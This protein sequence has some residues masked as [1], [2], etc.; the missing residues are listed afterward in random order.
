MTD[1][2]NPWGRS[3]RKK[4]DTHFPEKREAV[5]KA[6]AALFR[7]QGYERAS[8]NDLADILQITKPTIYYY[9]HSKEQL[10]LDILRAAQSEILASFAKAAASRGSGYEKLRRIMVDYA[11]VMISDH[12]ACMARIPSR[13]FE[14]PAARAE[15]EQRIK[16][17]DGF[18]YAIIDEGISDGT[19]K[20]VDRAVALHT[21]FGSLNWT[22]YWAKSDGRLGPEALAEAQVELLLGGVRGAKAPAKRQKTEEAIAA[23]ARQARV[24][25]VA[26]PVAK[27]S[28]AP[29]LQEPGLAKAIRAKK[30][31]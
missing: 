28:D 29:K 8:L 26:A 5:V 3:P 27:I 21:L 11:L 14:E 7:N 24:R 15:V 12:G 22:A 23:P 16:E 2:S 10:L 20:I 1:A 18:I 4:R 19:L 31:A 6:A 9:V 13:A 25:K 17:A 30:S